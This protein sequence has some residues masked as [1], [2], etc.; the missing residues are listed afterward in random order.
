MRVTGINATEIFTFGA[1]LGSTIELEVVRTLNALRT[2]WDPDDEYRTFS[3]IR[4]PEGFPDVIL[5]NQENDVPLIGI[6]LKSWYIL[7]KEGEPSFRFHVSPAVCTPADLFVVVPWVLDTVLSGTPMI[8]AP[9]IEGARYVAEFRNYWW[10]HLRKTTSNTQI[11]AP[12]DPRPFPTARE[13]Y[14][15]SPVDD[16]GNNFGRIARIGLLDTWV[17]SFEDTSLL[18]IELSRWRGFFRGE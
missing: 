1:V 10:Q 16:R 9:Y 7:A 14:N 15:D 13:N 12:P 4:Q 3:F 6:E 18:G 5:K 17:R 8:L 11:L 2:D